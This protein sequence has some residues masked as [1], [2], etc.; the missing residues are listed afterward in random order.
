MLSRLK[1]YYM[2]VEYTSIPLIICF[3]L[4]YLSG[5]GLIK[6]E[7]VKN[8]TLGL[9]SYPESMWLHTISPLNYIL[10]ILVLV[11]SVAGLNLLAYRHIKCERIKFAV[12]AIILLSVGACSLTLF[13]LLEA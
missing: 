1:V 9:I 11:H 4:S 12:E 13:T 2:L 8:L 3:Y 5:K 10:A 6:S 7:V